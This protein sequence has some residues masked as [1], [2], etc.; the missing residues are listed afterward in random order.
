MSNFLRYCNKWALFC[1]VA[2]FIVTT[3]VFMNNWIDGKFVLGKGVFDHVFEIISFFIVNISL[4]INVYEYITSESR[5]NSGCLAGFIMLVC[6][7]LL[8]LMAYILLY[9]IHILV[10]G[11]LGIFFPSIS[12][13]FF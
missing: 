6:Y 9:I 4:A 1:A 13:S 12:P 3:I 11:F 8:L 5:Q 2:F 10:F 7:P